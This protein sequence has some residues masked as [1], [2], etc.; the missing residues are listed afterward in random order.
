MAM[1][2]APWTD[3]QVEALNQFQASRRMHPFTCGSGNRTDAAQ[4]E[5]VAQHGMN[6]AVLLVAT[7]DGWVCQACDYTQTWAHGFMVEVGK[8]GPFDPFAEW[9]REAPG[10]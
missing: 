8:Q 5:A 9:S 3:E 7:N 4:V 10:A 6:D 1:L 2:V